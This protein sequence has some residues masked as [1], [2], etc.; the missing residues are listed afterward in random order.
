MCLS[1][2]NVSL[3]VVLTRRSCGVSSCDR[4]RRGRDHGN[5]P[6]GTDKALRGAEQAPV[7]VLPVPAEPAIGRTCRESCERAKLSTKHWRYVVKVRPDALAYVYARVTRADAGTAKVLTMKARRIA[8]ASSASVGASFGRRGYR[9]HTLITRRP[10]SD[11][12]LSVTPTMSRCLGCR[13]VKRV[14]RA[15]LSNA[16]AMPHYRRII[17][18]RG[19]Q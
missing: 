10:H 17:N 6:T 7:G 3:A 2:Y 12:S 11:L 8:R 14:K 1:G 5:S 13:T 4:L 18:A 16:M 19:S 15:W 9:R